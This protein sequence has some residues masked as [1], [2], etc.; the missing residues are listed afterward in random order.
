MT[1]KYIK[2]YG[3]PEKVRLGQTLPFGYDEIGM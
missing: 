3:N 2:Q 1:R